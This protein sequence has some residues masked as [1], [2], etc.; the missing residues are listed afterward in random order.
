[1]IPIKEEIKTVNINKLELYEY[2]I[3]V[4]MHLEVHLKSA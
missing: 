2:K 4:F 1:M 3:S